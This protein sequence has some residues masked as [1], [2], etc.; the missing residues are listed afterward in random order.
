MLSGL[1][2]LEEIPLGTRKIPTLEIICVEYCS[3]FA[4][5]SVVKIKE[6][7]MQMGN[8]GL[9]IQVRISASALESFKEKVETEGL[10]INDI[11]LEIH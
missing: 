11:Q 10:S 2:H 6:D 7:E 3:E 9:Q 8:D 4:A 5:I 1:R